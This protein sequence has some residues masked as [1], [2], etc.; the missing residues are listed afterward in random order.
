MEGDGSSR[1]PAGAG[2]PARAAGSRP[3]DRGAPRA[4]AAPAPRSRRTL[5]LAIGAGAVLVICLLVLGSRK[6]GAGAASCGNGKQEPGEEC[7]DGNQVASDRCLPT[8]RLGTCGDGV[9]RAEVEECDD[10]NR[11]DGDGC[12]RACLTCPSN[13]DSFASPTTGHC[14]WRGSEM[15][16]FKEAGATC[17]ARGGHL[18]SFGDDHEWREVNERL[19][20]G[21]N[22]APVWIG[23]HRVDRNG[24]RDYGWVSGERVL[25]ARWGIQEPRLSPADLDCAVQGEAGAWAAADC[26]ERRGFVCERAGWTVAARDGHAYRHFIA[27]V[28]FHEAAAACTGLGGHLVSFADAAEQDFVGARFPGAVW[29]GAVVDEKTGQFA[30]LT[31]EPFVY[32]DFAPGEP[33]VRSHR[34]LALEVDRRWYDRRCGDRHGFICEVE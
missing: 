16:T 24:L 33:N 34:C 7:D 19:L 26:D 12:S 18:A 5:A 28:T 30:W 10:G 17:A 1:R 3:G 15:L 9:K 23:L 32:K 21:G 6:F 29:I 31:G 8:C 4:G 25:A 13:A 22:T 27:R 14:Y 11:A 20:A 2:D